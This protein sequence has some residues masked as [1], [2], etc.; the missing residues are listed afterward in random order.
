MAAIPKWKLK[1]EHMMGCNC[2]YGCP[3]SFNAPPTYTTCEAV[4][5]YRIAEGKYGDL[6]L[7]GLIWAHASVWPG[8]LHELNGR[9]VVYLD[10]RASAEQHA[11]LEEIATGHAGGP[12]GV[13]MSTVTAGIEVRTAAIEFHLDGKKSW[14]RVPGEIDLALGPILNPVTG[15]EHRAS[16]LLPTGMTTRREDFYSADRFTVDNGQFRFSYPGRNALT[17]THTWRGP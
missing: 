17:F 3:C 2:N 9:S 11:A 4:G 14:F 10:A 16:A 7:D 15:E 5:A 8:P 6:T 12:I 1:V 13:L